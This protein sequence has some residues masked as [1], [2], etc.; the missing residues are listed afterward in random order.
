MSP[1]PGK[2]TMAVKSSEY[3]Q[4][5]STRYVP[6]NVPVLISPLALAKYVPE[7]CPAPSKVGFALKMNGPMS[8]MG[9]AA[10]TISPCSK[11]TKLPFRVASE[12]SLAQ[13]VTAVIV[14][15][16]RINRNDQRMFPADIYYLLYYLL[17]VAP[18]AL[19]G[20]RDHK[21]WSDS[22]PGVL[23]LVVGTASRKVREL[24]GQFCFQDRARSVTVVT[25]WCAI[26]GKP[27]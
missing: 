7:K 16:T 14:S 12:H 26:N 9:G 8:K 15:R 25:S 19:V 11:A 2:D 3:V 5:C 18:Y 24:T 22:P 27:G 20:A 10:T 4:S 21:K 17:G 6:E 23:H 13:V 1:I